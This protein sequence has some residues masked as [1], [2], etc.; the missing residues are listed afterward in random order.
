MRALAEFACR[1]RALT[2]PVLLYSL[3]QSNMS[4]PFDWV[5]E[6][7]IEWT[8]TTHGMNMNELIHQRDSE[9]GPWR[10]ECEHRIQSIIKKCNDNHANHMTFVPSDN[11]Y[12]FQLEFPFN[13]SQIVEEILSKNNSFDDRLEEIELIDS[14][15]LRTRDTVRFERSYTL[16]N[17]TQAANK[18][19]IIADRDHF[20]FMMRPRTGKT[21]RFKSAWGMEKNNKIF[22]SACIETRDEDWLS[23]YRDVKISWRTRA[24]YR[25]KDV[26]RRTQM[27]HGQPLPAVVFWQMIGMRNTRHFNLS[28]LSHC[29]QLLDLGVMESVYT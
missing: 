19:A 4:L 7:V 27:W 25:I 28:S 12:C 16:R 18:P 2:L 21:K 13:E 9:D 24:G 26:V 23:E 8:Q 1:T 15:H 3:R 29:I 11:V 6:I 14:Y 20:Y 5:Q 10:R 17:G 22:E